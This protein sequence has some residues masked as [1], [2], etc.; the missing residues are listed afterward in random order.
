MQRNID[1]IRELLLRLEALSEDTS[2][3]IVVMAD[4]PVFN[5]HLGTKISIEGYN[6]NQISYH[7]SLIAEAGFLCLTKEQPLIGLSFTRLSWQGH[8]YIDSIRGQEIWDKTKEGIKDTGSFTIDFVK[9][10]AIG[11]VKKKIE[12]NTGV[13]I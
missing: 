2:S 9:Q 3:S 13:V 1:L 5:S 8:D 12:D 4:N 7:L 10:L 6:F 11:F